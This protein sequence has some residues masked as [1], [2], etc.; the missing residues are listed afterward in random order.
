[1]LRRGPGQRR[2]SLAFA[3]E[4]LFYVSVVAGALFVLV[5]FILFDGDRELKPIP[6]TRVEAEVVEQ[7]HEYLKRTDVPAYGDQT[8][9]L[10]CW[11]EF[12]EQEFTVEYLN[13][14]SWRI[15]AFYDRV[16]Y[17]WRVDD[18]TLEVTR[19]SW[20][21]TNNPTIAC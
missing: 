13:L 3:A 10:N 19:D 8:Q 2:W 5:S 7:L 21:K 17:C 1:M 18:L 16:R 9:M 15:D 12:G 20:I 4:T 11:A 14:G 6:A